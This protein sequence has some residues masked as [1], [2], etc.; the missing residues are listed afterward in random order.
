MRTFASIPEAVSAVQ[1]GKMLIIVDHPRRENE[2]DLYIAADAATPTALTTMIKHAGGILCASITEGQARRLG[3]PLMVPVRENKE[4]TGVNFTVSVSAA[5]GITTGVS[6]HDRARTVRILADPR[7]RAKDIV[8]PGHVFGLVARQGGVLEREGHTEAAVDLSRLAGRAPAGVLCEIVGS[9]GRMAK[10]EEVFRLSKRLGI[11]IVAISD[12][13]AYLQAHP[14]P[15]PSRG[16]SVVRIASSKLPTPH[17]T[18]A[19]T[20]Y[21]SVLDGREHAALV[22]G[23]TRKDM[24]VR[25]HSSCLTGDTLFSLRCDCGEQ[26]EESMRRIGKAGAGVIVYASQEGRGIGLGNK[27]RAYALQDTGLDTVEAN[28]ALGFS[29]DQRTYEAAADIL[30]DLGVREVHLLTNNPVKEQGL[31]KFG[32]AVT[33]RVPLEMKPHKTDRAYLKIK[34]QKLG[35]RLSRV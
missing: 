5:R 4:K 34:K 19:I 33:K 20:A 29:A 10:R 30:K 22:L 3:L 23:K 7:S 9:S 2:G 18:F 32:I 17:G 14:L 13:V 12:L 16:S 35:H 26:L 8:K 1:K 11:K 28:L 27:I 6:A 31:G 21:R 15:R 25:V 24:L